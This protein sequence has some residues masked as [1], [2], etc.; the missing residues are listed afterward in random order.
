MGGRLESHQ[1]VA[2]VA[3]LAFVTCVAPLACRPAAPS[4]PQPLA[5]TSEDY[6]VRGEYATVKL[7]RIDGLTTE[8][9]RVMLKGAPADLAIDLPAVADPARRSRHW[10]LVT[11]AHVN[12][13]RLATFT[14]SESVKD[15]SIELPDGDAPLHFAAFA[16]RTGGGEVLVFATGDRASGPPS[17]FGHVSILG[18]YD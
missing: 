4:G 13:R 8:N 3:A 16:A 17:L 7:E 12:G 9:G 1:R 5:V 15:F 11:D 6:T 14:H 18:K 2:R 10:A